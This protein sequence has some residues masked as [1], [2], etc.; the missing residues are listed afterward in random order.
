MENVNHV[1]VESKA[2]KPPFSYEKKRE[3]LNF[4]RYYY[5]TPTASYACF[6]LA[7]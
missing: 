4:V 7:T 2:E 6:T 5:F 1:S 3:V